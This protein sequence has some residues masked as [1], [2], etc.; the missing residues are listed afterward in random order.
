MR[1]VGR[2]GNKKRQSIEYT[3]DAHIHDDVSDRILEGR[4]QQV[5]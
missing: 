4:L 3:I 5:I 2:K 1:Y